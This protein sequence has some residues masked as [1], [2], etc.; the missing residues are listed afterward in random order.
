MKLKNIGEKVQDKIRELAE[1]NKE[2]TPE[3]LLEEQ[4]I[5]PTQGEELSEEEIR[6]EQAKKLVTVLQEN[7]EMQQTIVEK[8]VNSEQIPQD[9]IDKSAQIAAESSEV[10][11]NLTGTLVKQA[12]DEATV[13][14]L[15]N[16]GISSRAIRME[17]INSLADEEKKEDAICKELEELYKSLKDF[18]S[19]Q[20][21]VQKLKDCLEKVDIERTSRINEELY[22]TIARVFAIQYCE[23]DGSIRISP[24]EAIVPI[25]EMIRAKMPQRIGKEYQDKRIVKS[26]PKEKKK[27][28]KPIENLIQRKKETF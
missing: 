18:Q 26:K 25:D 19:Q 1:E 7:P 24:M 20:D 28:I 13:D 11:D 15:Q 8:A 6:E 12:S 17:V 9:V 4:V 27:S 10:P 22:K 16:E 21:I 3:K 5:K 2:K 14:I 23:F